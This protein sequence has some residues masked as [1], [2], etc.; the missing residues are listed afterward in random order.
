MKKILSLVLA[1][2]LCLSAVSVLAEQITNSI[3]VSDITKVEIKEPEPIRKEGGEVKVAVAIAAVT[4]E[5]NAT[6]GQIAARKVV[7]E[8][9]AEGVTVKS[10]LAN[11]EIIPTGEDA[12]VGKNFVADIVAEENAK[13]FLDEII[14]FD[15]DESANINL[16]DDEDEVIFVIDF[17]SVDDYEPDALLVGIVAEDGS[18]VWYTLSFEVSGD[19]LYVKL[20]GELLKAMADNN[21]MLAALT[22]EG[23]EAAK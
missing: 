13:V 11:A 12:A 6:E 10:Y 23:A 4:E 16:L 2:A 14:A 1:L 20:T 15:V 9:A 19:A 21:C 8:M 18:V 17:T 22:F 5:G 3:T 7:E